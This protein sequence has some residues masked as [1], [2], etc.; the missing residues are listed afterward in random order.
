MVREMKLKRKYIMYMTLSV[1][2][3]ETLILSGC[4]EET[5]NR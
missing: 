2:V 3:I 1:A 5:T 4:Q